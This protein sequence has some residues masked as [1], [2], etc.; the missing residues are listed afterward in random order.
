[1][2]RY[3]V[4]YISANGRDKI[5]MYKTKDKATQA[6]EELAAK[7]RQGECVSMFYADCDEKGRL[8]S[9]NQHVLRVWS[10]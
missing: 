1:M 6:A 3:G 2:I 9:P 10:D 5:T 8:L 4:E 7:R